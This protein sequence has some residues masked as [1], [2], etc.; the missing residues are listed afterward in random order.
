MASQRPHRG[1]RGCCGRYQR[2]D[3]RSELMQHLPDRWSTRE[4]PVLVAAAKRL[5][6]DPRTNVRTSLLAEDTGL[7]EDHVLVAIHALTP[8]YLDT[9]Q[10][11]SSSPIPV[12]AD[13]RALT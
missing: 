13:V 1:P 10:V 4:L 6:A 2:T 7:D 12:R 8:S 9:M 11:T 5:D 3:S